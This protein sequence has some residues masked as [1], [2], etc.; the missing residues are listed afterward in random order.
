MTNIVGIDLGTT[1]SAISRVEEAGKPKIVPN[2]D[3]KNITPSVVEFLDDGSVL[4]GDEAKKSIGYNDENIVQEVKRSMGEDVTYERFGTTH[5]PITI[6]S[7]ILKKLKQD[8]EAVYGEIT[9]VVVTVPANFSNDAREATKKAA[10]LAGLKLE[11]TINEPTAAALAYALQSESNLNGKYAIYDLGGGTFD[12]TIATI[13][14]KNID[15]ETSEGVNKLGGKDF[16][17]KITE[18]VSSKYKEATG[19][20]LDPKEFTPNDAEDIKISLSSKD[21]AKARVAGQVLDVTR[22]EFE[23][24][25]STLITK[26]EMSVEAALRNVGID[27]S[28]IED[29]ILV[30]GS[31]RMPMVVESLKK[32]FGKEPKLFGN[33]DESVALGA[34][35]YAAHNTN[36]EDL[37]PL[38]RQQMQNFS[39]TEAAPFYFGT[40]YYNTDE[41]KERVRNIINKDEK[42]PCEFTENFVTRH[43]NQTAV[44]CSV[45]QAGADLDDP[46]MVQVIW[47]GTLDLPG[48]YPAGQPIQITYGYKEDG[49]MTCTFKDVT[50]GTEKNID[51]TI[52]S[53]GGM[54]L[55]DEFDPDAFQVD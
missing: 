40:I 49:T 39:L 8:F 52:G 21:S 9:S 15:V 25:T 53:D 2:K 34:S 50:S 35:I 30:G 19:Q 20:D 10:E 45:T 5:T 3:G 14:D 46:D 1:F 13:K 7:M 17:E 54:P 29:V 55:E 12:C 47:D 48:G 24:A 37:N 38:Q 36:S 4:V 32:M 18:I 23:A 22:E 51:L 27:A 26:A 41:G 28:G 43:D 16:D 6:S 33:P 42:I 44:D 31:T 11:H